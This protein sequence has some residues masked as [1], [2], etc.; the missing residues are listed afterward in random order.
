MTAISMDPV[1]CRTLFEEAG[2]SGGRCDL[3]YQELYSDDAL[4]IAEELA[5]NTTVTSLNMWKNNISKGGAK[6]IAAAIASNATLKSLDVEGN[7]VGD[8]GGERGGEKKQGDERE[9]LHHI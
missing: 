3:R 1:Q 4:V 2:L 8:V 9:M 7:G 6:A 5:V